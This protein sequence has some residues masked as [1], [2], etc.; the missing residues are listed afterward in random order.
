MPTLSIL[1]TS[2]PK[3]RQQCVLGMSKEAKEFLKAHAKDREAVDSKLK[4]SNTAYKEGEKST[5]QNLCLHLH[6]CLGM[7]T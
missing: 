2:V 6:Y 4:D 3:D 1:D 7:M 5:V